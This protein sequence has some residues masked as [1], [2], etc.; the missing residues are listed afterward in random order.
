MIED[1]SNFVRS[2]KK[3]SKT[4]IVRPNINH[5]F[6]HLTPS[7]LKKITTL[8]QNDLPDTLNENN[9]N[10]FQA[11]RLFN[12]RKNHKHMTQIQYHID[13]PDILFGLNEYK[14]ARIKKSFHS[15]KKLSSS[16]SIPDEPDTLEPIIE[17]KYEQIPQPESMIKLK[18][19]SKE[20]SK[21]SENMS[22]L[23]NMPILQ[24]DESKLSDIKENEEFEGL[25]TEDN[26]DNNNENDKEKKEEIIKNGLKVTI[27]DNKNDNN[28]E[29]KD[30]II[31]DENKKNLIEGDKKENLIE[32]GKKDNLIED[33][34]KKDNLIEDDYNK[35]N[36]TEEDKK[37]NLIDE[38]KKDKIN[39]KE[40]DNEKKLLEEE[41]I[42]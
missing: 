19:F 28:V 10:I 1:T 11:E 24:F 25:K 20:E 31:E 18:K 39:K 37:E 14:E 16:N 5:N 32:D 23:K 9:S 22:K 29:K 2:S 38:E 13:K 42:N 4:Q 33:D 7:D 15:I 3:T 30:G 17:D 12:V 34:N 21:N 26:R 27:D 35:K 8:K 36:L 6:N 41:R 40:N